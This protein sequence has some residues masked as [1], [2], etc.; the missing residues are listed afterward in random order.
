[1]A[2]VGDFW[3]TFIDGDLVIDAADSEPW[4]SQDVLDA[5]TLLRPALDQDLARHGAVATKKL[6]GGQ[7]RAAV[8]RPSSSH[9]PSGCLPRRRLSGSPA[10]CD[11]PVPG[12]CTRRGFD[13]AVHPDAA[14]AGAGAQELGAEE[15]CAALVLYPDRRAA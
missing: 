11:G 12:P 5:V 13:G 4:L 2:T 6:P 8:E 1:M 15:V 14:A 3:G 9:A 10:A 7:S